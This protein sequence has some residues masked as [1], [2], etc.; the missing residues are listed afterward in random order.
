MFEFFKVH[1]LLSELMKLIKICKR[2]KNSF[3]Q[4]H[5]FSSLDKYIIFTQRIE[6]SFQNLI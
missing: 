3:E 5:I 4:K 1:I 6:I 2:K